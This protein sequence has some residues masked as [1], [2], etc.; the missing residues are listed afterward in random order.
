[1]EEKNKFKG[2]ILVAVNNTLS[3]GKDNKLMYRIKDDMSR[4]KALTEGNVVIMGRKTFESLPSGK[5]LKNRVNIILT[6]NKDFYVD[7]DKIPENSEVYIVNSLSDLNDIIYAYFEDKNKYIIGG[8]QIYKLFLDNDMVSD[9]EM[10]WVDDETRG[11][12]FFPRLSN[13][14]WERTYEEPKRDSSTAIP[15][16][17]IHFIKK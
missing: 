13:D 3:I 6:N 8:S 14:E 7:N 16:Q 17:F 12:S 1:M 2:T 9:I 5:P 10:T 15:Y 4:F 11:D